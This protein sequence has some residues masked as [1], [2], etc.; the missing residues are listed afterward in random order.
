MLARKLQAAAGN[1]GGEAVYVEDVFSTYL[2][3]GTGVDQTITNGI[4][5]S[6]EGG[7]VWLKDRGPT[8]SS[9]H[10]LFDT[11]RGG[12]YVIQTNTTGAQ[13]EIGSLGGGV[14]FNTDGFVVKSNY[15]NYNRSGENIVSWTFRKASKFFDVVTYTGNGTAGR[16]VAH[17][18]GSVPA[19]IVVKQT[20]GTNAWPVYHAAYGATYVQFLNDTTSAFTSTDYWND[21][22]PT[23]TV[24]SLGINARVNASGSNYVAYVFAS[25]AGGYGDDGSENIIKCSSFTTDSSG[26]NFASVN[27]GFE[28]QWILFKKRTTTSQWTMLDNMRGLPWGNK[29]VYL[30]ANQSQLEANGQNIYI[31]LSPTGFDIQGPDLSLSSE[32]I[33]IAIRRPMKAPEL[34]TDVF[35]PVTSS[36]S[37]TR[38]ITTGFAAD[39]MICKDINVTSGLGSNYFLD[40][41]RGTT[42]SYT[43]QGN[44]ISNGTGPES[45]WTG[46]GV[47]LLNTTMV[48]NAFNALF[49]FGN[50][51]YYAF[52]RAPG[53]FDE[54]C[55]AGTGVTM[56]V[57]HSL[58]VAP[59]LMIVKNRG[60]TGNW[61]VNLYNVLGSTTGALLESSNAAFSDTTAWASYYPTAA[62][63][64]VG[65]IQDVN[66]SAYTYVA[67]LF[68]T[69][70]GIS[71]VGSYTGTAATLNVDCGFSAGARFI[72]IKRTDSTGDWYVWDSARG[73]VAGNDPYI[74]LNSTAAENASTDY[75]DPYSA[76]FTVTSTAPAGLNASSGTY[77]YL[78]IA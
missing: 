64:K 44:L 51:I 52:R 56:T 22:A 49:G 54:V 23:S 74:L 58:G 61:R 76:G 65:A 67:Y 32:Y 38:T 39:M 77:I 57:T 6:Q 11:E 63:F 40:K 71:K 25:D 60:T 36:A 12:D 17:N 42:N 68:A 59:E 4:N 16:T 19:F 9:S 69:F 66:N 75:I 78:A 20:D 55:Y 26:N 30:L 46:Y 37:G 1:A 15:N 18:L 31:K 73:I 33:Y 21:T 7:L 35:A 34:G 13:V 14:T 10:S 3:G 70:A 28:P 5:L 45:T 29:P 50:T 43:T 24:F 8:Y 41:L 53:F 72:L 27:C 48:D 47:S 62:D 2:Y